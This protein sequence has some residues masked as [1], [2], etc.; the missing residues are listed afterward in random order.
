VLFGCVASAALPLTV[1]QCLGLIEAGA[2]RRDARRV[3]AGAVGLV[4]VVVLA[5]APLV[6][7][8]GSGE[9]VVVGAKNFSEQSILADVM[10]DRLHAAGYAVSTKTD[11]GSVVAYR[12]VASGEIDA[13][14][15]Y[16]GTLWANVL[17]RTD[18]PPRKAMLDQL[19]A[20]LNS[21]DH[22]LVLG[23]L[24]FENAYALAMRRDRARALGVTSIADLAVHAPALKLG[25]D[26][27]FLS[28]PEWAALKTAYGLGFKAERR[29]QPTFMYKAV[30]GGEVDVISAFSSDGRVVADDL[31][32]LSDPKQAIPPY[33]AVILISPKRAGD[34]RFLAALRPLIGA[35]PVET[36]RKANLSVDRD[37]DKAT[38]E[39]A[40]RTLE[41][42]IGK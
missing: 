26:F 4:A 25:S 13:Y 40:A 14:V 19:T 12:A 8:G 16:S 9:K 5:L 39:Q 20:V 37:N 38:P 7:A 11:L 28:R 36:M 31:L 18:N 27:E 33:D 32:V 2:A 29:Y 6:V 42:S 21:R 1:D 34:P 10:A 23:P 30:A 22:V 17:K 15:D 35:I 41:A 24:G 3:V